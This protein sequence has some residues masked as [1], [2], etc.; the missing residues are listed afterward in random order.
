MA[1][2]LLLIEKQLALEMLGPATHEQRR[3]PILGILVASLLRFC[4]CRVAA[5]M[6]AL[7]R[8]QAAAFPMVTAGLAQSADSTSITKAFK[9]RAVELHP[10]KGPLGIAADSSNSSGAFGI[11][12]SFSNSANMSRQF[13]DAVVDGASAVPAGGD[14]EEFQ[15]LQQMKDV[16]L[17]SKASAEKQDDETGVSAT[18]NGKLHGQCLTSGLTGLPSH[19]Q[20][21]KPK[22]EISA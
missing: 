1:A 14:Q 3:F 13:D 10:D 7:C 11:G 5:L 12:E 19:A 4:G 21:L 6:Q 15:L 9:R 17:G 22:K 8:G 16:L 18:L 20:T 2:R